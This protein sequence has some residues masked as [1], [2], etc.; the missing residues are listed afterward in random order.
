MEHRLKLFYQRWFRGKV[1]LMCSTLAFPRGNLFPVTIVGGYSWVKSLNL[2]R[3]NTTVNLSGWGLEP[4]LQKLASCL[5]P[6]QVGLSDFPLFCPQVSQRHF[7]RLQL[8]F[9]SMWNKII[10]TLKIFAKWNCC[11]PASPIMESY[12]PMTKRERNVSLSRLQ[13]V[14]CCY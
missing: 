7:E 9:M 8:F 12:A 4:C 11:F 10:Q 6:W 13:N 5:F 14:K 3:V 2:S 1:C